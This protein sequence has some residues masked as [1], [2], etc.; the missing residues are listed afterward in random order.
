MRTWKPLYKSLPSRPLMAGM[1]GVVLVTLALPYSP[2][3]GPLGLTPLP[4][5]TLLRLAV[6]TLLYVELPNSRSA[7][8]MCER[9]EHPNGC[10]F[11]NCHHSINRG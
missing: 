2:L 11:A 8:S 5:S 10:L 9:F 4:F 6:I 3:S 7:S 1:I